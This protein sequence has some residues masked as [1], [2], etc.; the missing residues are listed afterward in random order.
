MNS[1][2]EDSLLFLTKMLIATGLLATLVIFRGIEKLLSTEMQ[3]TVY[4]QRNGICFFISKIKEKT[5]CLLN[6]SYTCF[7]PSNCLM[8][9]L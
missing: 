1:Q 6:Q 3:L 5:K 2:A 8:K 7:D 9:S 4:I